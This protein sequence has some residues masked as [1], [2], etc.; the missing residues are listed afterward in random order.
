MNKKIQLNKIQVE[1]NEINIMLKNF[2][3]DKRK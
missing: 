2:F 1:S 3:E